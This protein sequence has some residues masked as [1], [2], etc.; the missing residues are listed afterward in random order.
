MCIILFRMNIKVPRE[1]NSRSFHEEVPS[2]FQA[3]VHVQAEEYH[4]PLGAFQ[5]SFLEFLLLEKSQNESI[6]D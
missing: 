6:V 1:N 4:V 2:S 5:E 3:V